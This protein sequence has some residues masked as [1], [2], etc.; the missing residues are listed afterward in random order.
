MGALSPAAVRTEGLT[1]RF[2]STAAVDRLD[3]EVC[4]GEVFGF[5][6]PNGAGKSTTIRLLLGLLRATSGRALIFGTDASDAVS[7]HKHLAYVPAD[8]ALWPDL[9]GAETLALLGKLG[10]VG[11]D[12]AYQ[13]E[14]VERF[15]LQVDR[16][17]GTYSTGNRQKV[18]LVAAFATRARLLGLDE[19]TSGLDP[20]MEQEF[21]GCL[22]EAADRG[23]TIL[24]SSHHLAEVEAVC[25]R[26]GIL[27]AGQLVAVAGLD[28]LRRLRVTEVTA[29]FSGASP[30]LTELTDLPGVQ[31]A[32]RE[33]PTTITLR[34]SGPPG[35]ALRGLATAELVSLHV[36]EPSL[37]EIFLSYYGREGA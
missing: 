1:K 3:L 5:L 21:R 14:L 6:G 9:T 25:D 18:A 30:D 24:L 36:H 27:R 12:R 28:E 23:Q 13:A 22:R 35:P 20:L 16:R 37:E 17:C 7:A 31:A 33:S 34:L 8:V 29:N 11:T 4:P 32:E 10:S 26:V 2:G 19:P 15:A